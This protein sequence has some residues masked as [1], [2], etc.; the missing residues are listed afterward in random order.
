MGLNE[1]PFKPTQRALQLVDLLF[2]HIIK[3]EAGDLPLASPRPG[4]GCQA[5]GLELQPADGLNGSAQIVIGQTR[6]VYA[7]KGGVQDSL[8]KTGK[9]QTASVKR[10]S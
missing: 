9:R 2:G 7:H 8:E 10:I 4:I 5:N 1:D 3:P 6:K